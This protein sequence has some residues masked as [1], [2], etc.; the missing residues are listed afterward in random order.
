[1]K[2]MSFT[3]QELYCMALVQ[4]KTA[5]YGIPDMMGTHPR[6]KAD[7]II[8][9]MLKHHLVEMDLDGRMFLAEGYAGLVEYYCDCRKCLAVSLQEPGADTQHIVLWERN[10]R[11][12]LAQ[13]I[14]ERFVFSE[15]NEAMVRALLE[16]TVPDGYTLREVS[17]AVIPNNLLRQAKREC[18]R[19]DPAEAIRLLQRNGVAENVAQLIAEGL[20][21]KACSLNLMLM[22]L[23]RGVCTKTETGFLAGSGLMLAM[24]SEVINYRSCTVFTQSDTRQQRQAAAQLAERFLQKGDS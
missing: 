1:M 21:E 9:A 7:E 3:P 8:D 14:Y 5:M 2:N 17:E 22:D 4:G 13:C 18:V 6:E 12:L 16:R 19:S 20:Q 11:Y 24:R 10:G 15:V 23:T